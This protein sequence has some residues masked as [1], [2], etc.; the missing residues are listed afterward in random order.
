MMTTQTV[1]GHRLTVD[2]WSDERNK[3]KKR[4]IECYLTCPIRTSAPLKN[5]ELNPR[6]SRLY[7]CSAVFCWNNRKY[8]NE[9]KDYFLDVKNCINFSIYAMQIGNWKISPIRQ[10]KFKKIKSQRSRPLP[11]S[12]YFINNPFS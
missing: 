1:C 9:V 3:I 12:K 2:L 7:T 10:N 8:E 4:K 6:S 11:T 5:P